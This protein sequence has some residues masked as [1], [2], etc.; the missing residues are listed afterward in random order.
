MTKS[1]RPNQQLRRQGVKYKILRALRPWHRRLGI[2]SSFFI[3]LLA[4]TG[5]AINHSQDF[6]LDIAQVKQAWLLDYYGINAP[7]KITVFCI[8]STTG[9]NAESPSQCKTQ[10]AATDSQ[11]WLKDKLI[12]ESQLP[13]LAVTRVGDSLVA[14]DTRHVYLF[15]AA[16]EL[17]ETQGPSTGS[18]GHIGL[19]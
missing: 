5:V 15:S 1:R 8:A 14:I 6:N 16:G 9:L 18:P 7:Q 13:I 10:V 3:L 19:S 12:L 11:L 17:Y 2:L 4:V